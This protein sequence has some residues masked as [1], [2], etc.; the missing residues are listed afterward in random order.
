[1]F[2]SRILIWWSLQWTKRSGK[3]LLPKPKHISGKHTSPNQWLKYF[4]SYAH[5]HPHIFIILFSVFFCAVIGK[6]CGTWTVEAE[7]IRWKPC[8][9]EQGTCQWNTQQKNA[10]VR[11]SPKSGKYRKMLATRHI[12]AGFLVLIQIFL[13]DCSSHTLGAYW[14]KAILL[15]LCHP[16]EATFTNGNMGDEP[17]CRW[18]PMKKVLQ[19]PLST[20]K[21][22]LYIW[23]L[24]SFTA[25]PWAI[26][27][28]TSV[29]IQAFKSILFA[30][31][32]VVDM[33]I[34]LLWYGM[35]FPASGCVWLWDF[36]FKTSLDNYL[37]CLLQQGC[38]QQRLVCRVASPSKT[39]VSFHL[40]KEVLGGPLN[41]H[42]GILE[43]FRS[44]S[45]SLQRPVRLAGAFASAPKPW[46]SGSILAQTKT[47]KTNYIYIL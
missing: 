44:C 27:D 33:T 39:I 4:N 36:G 43:S 42:L 28:H 32:D 1:M 41:I 40:C 6:L 37:S 15:R 46:S 13:F 10:K 17:A 20:L 47:K 18:L 16:F 19:D 9:P 7:A 29:K 25:S 3:R 12:V 11:S 30:L 35:P 45:E 22:L 31:K 26:Q 34:G 14:T 2:L 23:K 24:R 21:N 38:T 5:L 8:L